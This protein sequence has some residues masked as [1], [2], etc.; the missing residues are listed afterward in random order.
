[1]AEGETLGRCN[2]CEH[3][4]AFRVPREVVGGVIWGYCFQPAKAPD[5]EVG[6]PLYNVYGK[7]GAFRQR[8]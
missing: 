6:L 7:C 3:F 4:S 5:D 8:R 1:M 2:F